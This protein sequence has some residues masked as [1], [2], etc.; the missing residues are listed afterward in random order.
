[1]PENIKTTV[2]LDGV[3]YR[4]LQALARSQKRPSA[5]LVREAVALYVVARS[6]TARPSSI[7]SARS[8]RGDVSERVDELLPGFGEL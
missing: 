3:D 5:Q 6:S 8:G 1:M 2:Y 7:G 4:R